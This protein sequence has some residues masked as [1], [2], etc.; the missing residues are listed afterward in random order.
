MLVRIRGPLAAHRGRGRLRGADLVTSGANR[1]QIL[2]WFHPRDAGKRCNVPFPSL[3]TLTAV[4]LLP[5]D[6]WR[7]R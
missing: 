1:Y 3:I 6:L 7:S 5:S 2:P 4:M